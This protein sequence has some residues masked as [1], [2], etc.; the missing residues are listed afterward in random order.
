MQ[1]RQPF[2]TLTDYL[3]MAVSPVLIM[4]LVGSL[5]FFLVEVCYRGEH[6]GEIRWTLFWFVIAVVLVARI[7]IEQGKGYAA[8][9]GL[10][11]AGATWLYL[12]TVFPAYLLGLAL[13]A[14]VWWSAN[15]L[16]WDCTLID[17]FEDASGQGLLERKSAGAVPTPPSE[18]S[19]LTPGAIRA[20]KSRRVFQPKPELKQAH[21]APGLWVVYFSLAALPLFGLGQTLLPADQT[22][23]RQTAFGLLFLYLISS[24]GLLLTT[25]FLGLRRYLRQRRIQMPASIAL[26]WVESGMVTALV[27]LAL[28]LLVPRPGA[29][30]TLATLALTLDT[31]LRDASEYA[32][33]MT[34]PSKT[35]A[36]EGQPGKVANEASSDNPEVPGERGESK[37]QGA[38]AKTGPSAQPSQPEPSSPAQVYTWLK[39]ILAASGFLWLAWW[40]YRHRHLIAQVLRAVWEAILRFLNQLLGRNEHRS[41][42]GGSGQSKAS[43]MVIRPF[44]AY[45]N[46]FVSQKERAWPPELVISYTYEAVQAWSR[47]IGYPPQPHQTPREF[48]LGLTAHQPEC[49]GPLD[50]LAFLYAH[51]AY[52]GKINFDPDW[53]PLRQLWRIMSEP[54]AVPR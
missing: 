7:G 35:E 39:R 48:C 31:H 46:P 27:V 12:L 1:T 22:A 5:V 21:H 3:V 45:R 43:S 34:A 17:E 24:L 42:Q 36:P 33:R 26:G 40:I 19:T 6:A 15:K 49:A 53:E 18:P 44:S 2:R 30:Y 51:A 47:G 38:K 52:G 13:L 11:L 29:D 32:M 16:T 28:A 14:V 9:Y 10:A 41:G 50:D 37:R 20:A 25:S 4:L 23:A 54:A 8:G